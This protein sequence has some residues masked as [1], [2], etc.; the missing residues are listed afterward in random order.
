DAAGLPAAYYGP[1]ALDI[2]AKGT[3]NLVLTNVDG[4]TDPIVVDLH[5]VSDIAILEGM[6]SSAGGIQVADVSGALDNSGNAF[7]GTGPFATLG[8]KPGAGMADGCAITPDGRLLYTGWKNMPMV[9]TVDMTTLS[10]VTSADLSNGALG[11]G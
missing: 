6:A 10:A 9:F 2:G 4:S 1:A 7:G 11:I 8:F 5:V 3:R